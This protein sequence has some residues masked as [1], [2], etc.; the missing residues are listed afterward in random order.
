[1]PE[2]GNS[3]AGLRVLLLLI[4][5]AILIIGAFQ[6]GGTTS[7]PKEHASEP[8]AE[9]AQG[10]LAPGVRKLDTSGTPMRAWVISADGRE[11]LVVSHKNGISVTPHS[12]KEGNP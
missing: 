1:M 12:R 7:T 4:L 2:N 10:P 3:W 9:H 8:P 11:Y 6:L 5:V